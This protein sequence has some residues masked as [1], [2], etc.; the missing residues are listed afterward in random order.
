MDIAALSVVMANTSVRQDAS[1]AV[2]DNAMELMDQKGNDLLEML[3]Q[4][5]SKASHPT[6]GNA[7][8]VRV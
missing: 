3:Q 1:I 8:D 5:G 6:L 4:S 7:V 2:M